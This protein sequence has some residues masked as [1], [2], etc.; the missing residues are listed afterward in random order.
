MGTLGLY[1]PG[2]SWLHR[3]PAWTKLLG[4]VLVGA[5]SVAI[6]RTW[7]WVVVSFLVVVIAYFSAGFGPKL[8]WA[9]IRPTLVLLLVIAA[10][11]WVSASWQKAVAVPGM[12]L[13]L[14]AAAAL[15]TLTTRTTDLIDVIVT[16]CGPFRRFGVD[17]ERVGLILL[18][19]IRF[20]PVV[21]E[22]AAEISQ[23]QT[24]RGAT[25]DIRAFAVPLLVRALRDADSIGEAL[26]ARG[27]D[28]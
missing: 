26:V 14:V 17:P 9:Q 4:L 7:W 2:T 20:V 27:F 10:M 1:R 16:A 19:G 25:R 11:T 22:L 3:A 8:V 5:A 23:A 13:V 6:Q 24:A 15:V 12:I 18:L 28:D 21:A